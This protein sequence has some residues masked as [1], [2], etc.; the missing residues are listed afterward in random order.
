MSESKK[1]GLERF[2]PEPKK[3][4]PCLKC[5][6]P[7]RTTVGRRIC[8]KCTNENHNVRKEPIA[9]WGRE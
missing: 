2:K 1:A 5:G 6:K 4:L 3:D 7:F 8:P 9:K